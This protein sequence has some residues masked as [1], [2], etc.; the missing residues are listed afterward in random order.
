MAFPRFPTLPNRVSLLILDNKRTE[1]D[2]SLVVTF[3]ILCQVMGIQNMFTI[4]LRQLIH[5]LVALDP[6]QFKGNQGWTTRSCVYDEKGKAKC[7]E[8]HGDKPKH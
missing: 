6:S 3:P 8:Q 5:H 4:H 1:E 7:V 2:Y